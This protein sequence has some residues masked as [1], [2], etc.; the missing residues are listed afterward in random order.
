MLRACWRQGAV[1]TKPFEAHTALSAEAKAAKVLRLRGREAGT[2]R[3]LTHSPLPESALA[4]PS[5]F[6]EDKSQRYRSVLCLILA[7]LTGGWTTL[8][9]RLYTT[10]KVPAGSSPGSH[11]CEQLDDIFSIFLQRQAHPQTVN[12]QR[13]Q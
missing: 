5:H 10:R 4:L 7:H 9:G 13:A 2:N 1:S 8:R 11:S 12:P 6:S 3:C